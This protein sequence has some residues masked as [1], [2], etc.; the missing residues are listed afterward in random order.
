MSMITKMHGQKIKRW[1]IV[2][3][4]QAYHPCPVF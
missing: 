2:P 1:S 3:S 4:V